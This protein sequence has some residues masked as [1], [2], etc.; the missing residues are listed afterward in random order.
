MKY[1]D[2]IQ[3]DPVETVIK[4]KEANIPDKAKRLVETYVISERMAAQLS[5][6]I[7][8]HL[9]WERPQDNKALL[10]V[11]NYGTGKS[12]LMSLISAL[13]ERQDC[14]AYV[15]NDTVKSA[16]GDI[17]GKFKVIRTEIGG[18]TT[19]LREIVCMEL[20]QHLKQMGINFRFPPIDEIA[21]NSGALSDMMQ[22]FEQAYPNHGLL[23]AVDELLDYLRGRTVFEL[24]LDLGF[25][26]EIGEFCK[27][28]RFRFMA[29]VQE[30]LF[31]SDLFSHVA[32]SVRRVRDR[33]EQA[34]IVREDVTFVVSQR[35]LQKT[36]KQ[37][38][39]IRDHLKKFTPLYE[40]FGL[41][42][43]DFVELFPVHPAYLDTFERVRVAE[44]RE[45]LKTLSIS[46]RQLLGETVPDNAPGVLSFDS[47]WEF[48]RDNPSLRMETDIK[49]VIDRSAVIEDRIKSQF[50]RPDH[51]PLAL[52]LLHALS[53][54]RLTTADL[55]IEIGMSAAEL[56]EK[57]LVYIEQPEKEDPLFFETT[58]I[59]T[60]REIKDLMR[61][62]YFRSNPNN[63]Q[64]YLF[65]GDDIDPRGLIE[66]HI[67][68]VSKDVLDESYFDLL[69][70]ALSAPERK[71]IHQPRAREHEI[72]WLSRKVSRRGYLF[73]GSPNERN[74][75]QPPRDFYMYFRQPH[76]P[77][78]GTFDVHDDEVIFTLD[79]RDPDFEKQLRYY[80]AASELRRMG[81]SAHKKAFAAEADAV[82]K[83]LIKWLQDNLPTCCLV[84]YR[85]TKR[86]LADVT[87]KSFASV[88]ELIN[89]V[90]STLLETSFLDKAPD[91]PT[92]STLLTTANLPE[93]VT[94]ALRVFQGKATERGKKVLEGLLLHEA[95]T[96]STA[97]KY[98]SHFR[99][100]IKT[101]QVVNNRDVLQTKNEAT[102]TMDFR[103]EPELLVVVLSALVHSGE[104]EL[105]LANGVIVNSTNMEE[106]LKHNVGD[107]TKFRSYKQP[108]G[109][110]LA[111]AKALCTLVGMPATQMDNEGLRD[112][113]VATIQERISNG[114]TD[115]LQ[116]TRAI[117]QQLWDAYIYSEPEKSELRSTLTQL[118][119]F[120]ESL[121]RYNSAAKMRNLDRTREDIDGYSKLVACMKAV[122]SLQARVGD[123]NEL[124]TYLSRAQDKLPANH[125]WKAK[126]QHIRTD[127]TSGL[128]NP[129]KRYDP[130][131]MDSWKQQMQAAKLDYIRAYIELH[132]KGKLGLHDERRRDDLWRDPLLA[133]LRALRPIK[134]L[135]L[136]ELNS[137]EED[138]GQLKACYALTEKD[139]LP[140]PS[141]PHCHFEPTAMKSTS[142]IR[143]TE[144][145]DAIDRLYRA[146]TTSLLDQLSDPTL[147]Q[148]VATLKPE[149]RTLIS[150]FTAKR[151]LPSPITPDFVQAVQEALKG[152]VPV[153][154][155]TTELHK[156]L[157][158]IPCTIDELRIRFESYVKTLCQGKELDRIRIL[159]T[160]SEREKQ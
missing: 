87:R 43:E 3:F 113:V 127:L 69:A 19:P 21:N 25:L 154:V 81:N 66:S 57:L 9:Q 143:L 130:V 105:T 18:V 46:I 142:S 5:D 40:D 136:S 106:L 51:K 155:T 7:F 12:H 68:N 119:Q 92:F 99:S 90:A 38:A 16:A 37:R 118:K 115:A 48:V 101:E 82:R 160:E 31:D 122:L 73:F 112:Q 104:V 147:Q 145:G 53:V 107:L 71:N 54:H 125:P 156:A 4:L 52:R 98:A 95:G 129:M 77:P 6:L 29:G 28:S 79:K 10:V 121:Q 27:D 8:P 146:S 109:F 84:E 153:T 139:L 55:S 76:N 140:G 42:L 111:A 120:L 158:G 33:F 132:G 64:Y 134:S 91:Y 32:D 117:E 50:S 11:G 151:D 23:L 135:P 59:T 150:Q 124:C 126:V 70:V 152:V 141:C 35:L 2:L 56:R 44:K 133:D 41:K 61:G 114:V 149:Q 157:S 159:V 80:A 72:E 83:D 39:W 34:R 148:C 97:T 36:T 62:S 47:Y 85:G 14:V 89:N 94:D 123:L 88:D 116:A 49:L 24:T 103:L 63:G 45:V 67:R 131:T 60:L 13:A 15:K 20:E 22:A 86:K 138:L 128:Q 58:I 1:Q 26:R 75:A 100:L 30:S 93:A 110:P 144:I 108:K 137:L 74:T 102:Y 96:L 65:V 78:V 17:A